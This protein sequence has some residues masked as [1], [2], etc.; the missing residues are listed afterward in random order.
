MKLSKRQ[1]QIIAIVKVE[2]PISGDKIAEIMEISRATLR[3][4]LSFLTLV[5]ILK[6][7]PK[8]G[9]TYAGA[10]LESLFFFDIFQVKIETVM[11]APTMVSQDTVIQDAIITL[12][13]YDADVLYVMN[14]DKKLT[15][16]LSRK[17]L[18]RASLN[19]GIDVTPVAV[20]MTRAPHIKTCHQ[21]MSI[22][23]VASLLQDFEVDSLPVVDKT[24]EERV[25]GTITNTML[26]NFIISQARQAEIQRGED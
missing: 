26:L 20:C 1:K 9:Y 18:L 19:K 13:M 6:A 14:K 5:G 3:A 15:G 12:F 25:V 8:L 22:L 11:T 24:D 16:L 23:E 2:Q 17:D 21:D 10:D 7:R 4:D